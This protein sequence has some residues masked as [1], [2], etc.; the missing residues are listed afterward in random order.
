MITKFSG[1]GYS[2]SNGIDYNKLASGNFS[3]A[4]YL[5]KLA[6]VESR[7]AIIMLKNNLRREIYKINKSGGDESQVKAAVARIRNVIKKA[8]EKIIRLNSEKRMQERIKQEKYAEKRKEEQC[9]SKKYR[10]K[11]YNRKLS[12]RLNVVRVAVCEEKEIRNSDYY[13][14]C[15]DAGTSE[16]PIANAAA[17]NGSSI[18]IMI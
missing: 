2:Y 4:R 18:D 15:T 1:L 17:G 11:V 8:D 5:S 6:S 9:L 16:T 3:S 10:S 13:K 12:E 7:G 14:A